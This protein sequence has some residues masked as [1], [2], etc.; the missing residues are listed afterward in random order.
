MK[1]QDYT[2]T[3][4]DVCKAFDVSR[5]TVAAWIKSD[6]PPPHLWLGGS[7]RFSLDEVTSWAK[8]RAKTKASK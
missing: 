5:W 7:Y 1:P 3:L 2:A 6:D 8:R 4:A